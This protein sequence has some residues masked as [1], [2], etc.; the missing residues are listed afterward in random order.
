MA[1]RKQRP[2]E[3]ACTCKAYKF[4]HRGGA[5]N[6]HQVTPFFCEKCQGSGRIGADPELDE[7]GIMCI[8]CSG[9]GEEP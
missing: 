5:G 1:K 9:S 4:P 8:R 3:W 7:R 2:G 6:C